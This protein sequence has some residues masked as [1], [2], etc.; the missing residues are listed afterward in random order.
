MGEC[1]IWSDMLIFDLLGRV[2]A[3][4]P[5]A[6]TSVSPHFSIF[7]L[8]CIRSSFLSTL[9]LLFTIA[10]C[11]CQ[12]LSCSWI[13]G[14]LGNWTPHRTIISLLKH[15]ID[16]LL[17]LNSKMVALK[18]KCSWSC[19]NS[20][21]FLLSSRPSFR[22]FA[23]AIKD[24]FLAAAF[25]RT[26]DA[27]VDKDFFILWLVWLTILFGFNLVFQL[28]LERFSAHNTHSL[29]SAFQHFTTIFLS[30]SII[31]LGPR[32]VLLQVGPF[33]QLNKFKITVKHSRAAPTCAIVFWTRS[34]LAPLSNED[35][36][37][38]PSSLDVT[39][40]HHVFSRPPF[41]QNSQHVLLMPYCSFEVEQPLADPP[42]TSSFVPQF[43]GTF[44]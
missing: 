7:T 26:L 36:N 15:L 29:C 42:R 10:Q 5:N 23:C 22:A 39:R 32:H 17:R 18:F 20:N 4:H 44:H 25:N 35:F 31:Q 3:P 37:S 1:A 19:C 30:R 41:S 27:V 40:N 9:H 33:Q 12:P 6:S 16:P 2:L 11:T 21:C 13:Q 34:T 14:W 8:L 43:H 24:A 28:P 38:S